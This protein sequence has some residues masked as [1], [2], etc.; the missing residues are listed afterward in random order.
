MRKEST[1]RTARVVQ[2]V[3]SVWALMPPVRL[4]LSVLI[5]LLGHRRRLVHRRRLEHRRQL[6]VQWASG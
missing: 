1:V 6:E 5:H 3:L 2:R 4:V